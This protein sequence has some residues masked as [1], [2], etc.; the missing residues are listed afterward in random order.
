MK[1]GGLSN[2]PGQIRDALTGSAPKRAKNSVTELRRMLEGMVKAKQ[3]DQSRVG[4]GE[5]WADVGD[6]VKIRKR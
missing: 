6:G 4:G 3:K 1:E 2:V 5:G